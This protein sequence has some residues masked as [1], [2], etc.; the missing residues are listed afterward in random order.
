MRKNVLKKRITKV[1]FAAV[2]SLVMVTTVALES[3]Y[4]FTGTSPFIGNTY[5]HNARFTNY[6][7][8]NGVDVSWWQHHN[9]NWDAA[10]AAGVDYAIIRS[11]YTSTSNTKNPSMS[12]DSRFATHYAKAKAAGVM[13]GV[14]H[15][16]QARTAAEAEKE[17]QFTVN[18]LKALG[19]GPKDLDLPVYFDYEF[20][21]RLKSKLSGFFRHG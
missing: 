9:S 4:A 3:A 17:A 14:Y 7:V 19:I 20:N 13:V 18:R 6:V 5:N 11:T 12:A 10:K 15:F 8:A 21:S 16:S 2:L 1:M